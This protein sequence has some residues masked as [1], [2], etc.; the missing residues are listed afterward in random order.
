MFQQIHHSEASFLS[1]FWS[2]TF[3]L[4]HK[5]LTNHDPQFTQLPQMTKIFITDLILKIM[6]AF[7]HFF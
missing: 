7:K 3:L 2:M 4:K 1:G 6:S 5:D